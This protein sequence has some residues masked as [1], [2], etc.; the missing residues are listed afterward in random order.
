VPAQMWKRFVDAATPIVR[1]RT[2]PQPAEP[3]AATPGQTTGPSCNLD[4]CAARYHSFRSADCT[5]Q[6]WN[7]GPR[8]MCELQPRNT[9]G[10]RSN[11]QRAAEGPG[12]TSPETDA[13]PMRADGLRMDGRGTFREAPSEPSMALGGSDPERQIDMP[14]RRY[15]RLRRPFGHDRFRAPDVDFGF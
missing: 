12:G 2:E 1:A 6:P 13:A 5:Y 7:G 4:A 3:S 9:S 15:D 10:I 8:R 14:R 11:S